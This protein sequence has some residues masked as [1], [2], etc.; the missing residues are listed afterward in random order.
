VPRAWRA[1][2]RDLVR[3]LG[4]EIAQHAAEVEAVGGVAGDHGG[5]VLLQALLWRQRTV[6]QH[7][8]QLAHAVDITLQHFQPQRFLAGEVVVERAFRH[9]GSVGNILDAGGVE[10]LAVQELQ[11]GGDDLLFNVCFSHDYNMTGRLK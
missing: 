1:H 6:L 2:G 10:A 5:K 4:A 3:Q 9:P 11:A 8:R 7:G